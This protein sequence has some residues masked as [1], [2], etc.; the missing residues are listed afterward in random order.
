MPMT[1]QQVF[2]CLTLEN[3]L[4]KKNNTVKTCE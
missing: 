3:A 1:Q 4:R 2:H